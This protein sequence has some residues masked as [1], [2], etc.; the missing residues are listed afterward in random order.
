MDKPSV[1][2]DNEQYIALLDKVDELSRE[3]IKV[4]GQ[5]NH[6]KNKYHTMKR[7]VDKFEGNKV[8]KQHFRK[9]Q[10]R[11]KRGFNG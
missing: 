9:G 11:G 6:F 10:K 3:L 4:T 7:I 8:E 5:R 1:S 2:I